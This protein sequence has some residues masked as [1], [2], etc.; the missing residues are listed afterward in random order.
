MHQSGV[1]DFHFKVGGVGGIR[2]PWLKPHHQK[3]GS[4]DGPPKPTQE[5]AGFQWRREAGGAV[6][7]GQEIGRGR[8]HLLWVRVHLGQPP[9]LIKTCD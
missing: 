8:G 3:T 1:L 9:T 7:G 4:N 2:A 5:H 6:P